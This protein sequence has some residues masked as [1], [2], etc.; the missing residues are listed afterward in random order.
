MSKLT[1]FLKYAVVYV[2][3]AAV[4]ML[5]LDGGLLR[6]YHSLN[7]SGQKTVG[8]VTMQTCNIHQTIEYRFVINNETFTGNDGNVDCDSLTVGHSIPVYYLPSEPKVNISEEPRGR[9]Q[10]EYVF[11]IGGILML[12]LGAAYTIAIW[13]WWLRRKKQMSV[14]S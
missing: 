13:K 10:N 3:L 7:Q 14:G 1:K 8:I 9:F 11:F 6:E 4:V 12:L 5:W 2:L